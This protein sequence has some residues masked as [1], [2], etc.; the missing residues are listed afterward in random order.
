[1]NLDN[2][3]EIVILAFLIILSLWLIERVIAGAFKTVI[4]G[5]FILGLLLGYHYFFHIE[6]IKKHEKPLPKF[7]ARDFTDYY[8]FESKFD[9]YK[10]QA[11][12]DIKLNYEE[13]KKQIKE[14]NK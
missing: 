14:N 6:K 7:T 12:K 3:L 13:A 10:D 4:A 11:V 2:P 9:L 8:L 1:M 5:I